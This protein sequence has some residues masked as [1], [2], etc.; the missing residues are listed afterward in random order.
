MRGSVRR[1]RSSMSGD[2]STP[3]M[4][5]SGKRDAST[6]VELPG[7]QPKSTTRAGEKS[8]SCPTRSKA[9]WV[10]WLRI[11]RYCK[12]DHSS[13]VSS[14]RVIL[15]TKKIQ[16]VPRREAHGGRGRGRGRGGR[17]RGQEGI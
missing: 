12:A 8:G 11:L 3:E 1:A 14:V 10:R 2:E 16:V 5:A 7:P 9:A 17:P 13:R 4:S 6:A 15:G